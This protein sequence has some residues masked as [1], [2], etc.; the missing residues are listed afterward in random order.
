MDWTAEL[1][2]VRFAQ[3]ARQ[4]GIE[5]KRH[6]L[7]SPAFRSPPRVAGVTRSIR[8]RAD[9]S[10]TVSVQLRGRP[11]VAVVADMIDGVMAANE[12][13]TRSAAV[14]DRLWSAATPLLSAEQ[15]APVASVTSARRH[16]AQAP[17]ARRAA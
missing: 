7:R 14:R 4:L 1:T 17:P 10:A 6:G 2:S 16:E 11:A 3:V 8:R 5:A 15:D 12:H 9:G 13:S